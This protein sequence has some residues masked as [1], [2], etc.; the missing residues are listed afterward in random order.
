MRRLG[1][2]LIVLAAPVL[3]LMTGPAAAGTLTV[4]PGQVTAEMTPAEFRGHRV[5]NGTAASPAQIRAAT[6]GVRVVQ[7]GRG[8]G[9]QVATQAGNTAV[10]VQAG[11]GHSASVTQSG[12]QQGALVI[13]T[14]TGGTADVVQQTDGDRVVVV[15]HSWAP[16]R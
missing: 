12:S 9:A 13:Q 4:E 14:G 5:Q 7:A 1:L 15:Q 8:H 16:R 6:G 2:A 3:G 11:S 10:V